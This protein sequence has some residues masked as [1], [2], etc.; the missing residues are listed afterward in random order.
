MMD[1]SSGQDLDRKTDS[2]RDKV[3]TPEAR[4]RYSYR[5]ETNSSLPI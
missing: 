1:R 4:E 2:H 3:D 5:M